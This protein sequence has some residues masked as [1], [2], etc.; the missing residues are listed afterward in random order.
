MGITGLVA[1]AACS[2][3]E[4]IGQPSGPG[5]VELGDVRLI[6]YDSCDGLLDWFHQ[7]AAGRVTA[8]GLDAAD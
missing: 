6:S 3:T 5:A 8:Y 4:S 7:E 2:G 1:L